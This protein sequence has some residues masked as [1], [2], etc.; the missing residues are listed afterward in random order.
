MYIKHIHAAKIYTYFSTLY[1]IL[2]MQT[3]FPL[4]AKSYILEALS[5]FAMTNATQKIKQA[6][7]NR[8][9]AQTKRHTHDTQRFVQQPKAG[10]NCVHSSSRTHH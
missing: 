2:N 10:V 3:L 8:I 9:V 6:G 4:I 5:H 7:H 1:W